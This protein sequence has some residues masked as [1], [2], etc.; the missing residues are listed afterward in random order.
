M[1]PDQLTFGQKKTTQKTPTNVKCPGSGFYNSI[2]SCLVCICFASFP[3]KVIPS[4]RDIYRLLVSA[5]TE[6]VFVRVYALCLHGIDTEKLNV[7]FR[8]IMNTGERILCLSSTSVS[9]SSCSSHCIHHFFKLCWTGLGT[10]P[11]LF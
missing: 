7:S 6:Y 11:L 4:R 2:S 3:C 10:H 5:T 1:V 8:G 9:V